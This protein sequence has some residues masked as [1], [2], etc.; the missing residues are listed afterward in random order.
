MNLKK[1]AGLSALALTLTMG[2]MI[3][4]GRGVQAAGTWYVSPTG[5]PSATSGGSCTSPSFNTISLAIAAASNGDTIQVCVGTYNEQV[6]INKTLTLNGAKAGQ[7][8]R[9]RVATNESIITNTCGPVQIMADKV[10]LDGF[11]IQGSTLDPTANPGCFGAGIWSNPGE[12]AS[13]V[14]GHQILNNIIQ[15]NI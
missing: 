3:F 2:L 11:T 9:T 8:A 10:V 5:A 15:N 14:G 4:G 12:F 7:D 13:D 6:Q 1:V